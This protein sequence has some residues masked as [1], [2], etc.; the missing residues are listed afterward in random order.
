MEF[1]LFTTRRFI[2]PRW[3]YIKVVFLFRVNTVDVTFISFVTCFNKAY[4]ITKAAV[5][6]I[7]RES[8][9]EKISFHDKFFDTYR[10]YESFNSIFGIFTRVCTLLFLQKR[11]VIILRKRQIFVEF[12][13]QFSITFYNLFVII[14]LALR[15]RKFSSGMQLSSWKH[16]SLQFTFAQSFV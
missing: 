5:A 2:F 7:E 11:I 4:T 13:H 8:R 14:K 1:S 10:C 3:K 16:P 9:D 15:N 6:R 12:I